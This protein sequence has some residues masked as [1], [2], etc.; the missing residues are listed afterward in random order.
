[1][2]LKKSSPLKLLS[3]SQPNFAEMILRW[4]PFK[5]VS[6]SCSI[7]WPIVYIFCFLCIILW[8]IVYISK[9]LFGPVNFSVLFRYIY[10]RLNNLIQSSKFKFSFRGLD[11]LNTQIHNC[12]LLCLDKGTLIFFKNGRGKTS[13][14]SPNLPS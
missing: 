11:T 14:M 3:Q 1:M 2:K 7:L 8:L 10:N 5:I 12:C 6:V 13:F 4:S 9:T